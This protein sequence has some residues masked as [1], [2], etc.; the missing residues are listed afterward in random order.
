MKIYN[1]IQDSY[2]SPEVSKLLK[3]HGFSVPTAGYY[4]PSAYG[5]RII[6]DSAIDR[7]ESCYDKLEP[8]FIPHIYDYNNHHPDSDFISAPTQEVARKWLS[9]NYE[10][11]VFMDVRHDKFRSGVR[12]RLPHKPKSLGIASW[13]S[14]GKG[15]FQDFDNHEDAIN[16]AILQTFKLIKERK[17][18]EEWK[19][20]QK[21]MIKERKA[22]FQ[23]NTKKNKDAEDKGLA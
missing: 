18:F 10:M 7:N 4:Y 9:K 2:C 20:E 17:E 13:M 22:M 3:E 8:D 12:Y 15:Q 6:F 19:E 14:N 11:E 1:D 23:R 21:R 16:Q 5:D